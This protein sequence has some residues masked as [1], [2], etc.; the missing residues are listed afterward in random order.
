MASEVS[1]CM[2]C[3]EPLSQLNEWHYI[4]S[5]AMFVFC[6]CG[7]MCWILVCMRAYSQAGASCFCVPRSHVYKSIRL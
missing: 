1:S 4:A 5:D 2:Y 3:Q 6:A 7:V